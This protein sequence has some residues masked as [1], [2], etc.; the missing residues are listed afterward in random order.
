VPCHTRK[1][2][3]PDVAVLS[4]NGVHDNRIRDTLESVLNVVPESVYDRVMQRFDYD[5]RHTHF[6]IPLDLTVLLPMLNEVDQRLVWLEG[7]DYM[8]EVDALEAEAL[9]ALRKTLLKLVEKAR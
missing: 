2:P 4:L 5:S 7:Q 9:N 8:D 3:A 6:E 1:N